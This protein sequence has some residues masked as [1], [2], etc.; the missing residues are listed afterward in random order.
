MLTTDMQKAICK[1]YSATDKTGQTNCRKCP[2]VISQSALM[3]F[4]NSHYDTQEDTWV[5]DEP[6]KDGGSEC[7]KMKVMPLKLVHEK[8]VAFF[9]EEIRSLE[10][11]PEING[12]AMTQEWQDRLDIMR[13]AMYACDALMKEVQAAHV[14][15]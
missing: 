10:L 13:Y 7:G 12:C 8:A 2:L 5:P 11:A 9:E 4:A 15:E 14:E 6:K 1:K 3:C